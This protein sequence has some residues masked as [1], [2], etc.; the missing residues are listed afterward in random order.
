MNADTPTDALPDS[1]PQPALGLA[2]HH[3]LP[4]LRIRAG[5][6]AQATVLLHGA[7]LVSWI[8][9]G[10]SEQLFVS[11][12][13]RH[14]AGQALRGGVPVIFPQFEQRGPLPRHGLARNRAWQ[15]VQRTQLP[16]HAMAV[17][18]LTDDE[19]TRAIWPQAFVC[20]LTVGIGGPRLDIEL[21]VTHAGPEGAEP[22]RFTAALHTYLRIGELRQVR[23]EGLRGSRYEDSARGG[24]KDV[25]V[26]TELRI[27]EEV[28]RIYLGA[29]RQTLL[30]RE[31]GRRLG[32]SADGFADVVV[33]NPGAEKAA[34][35]P[36]LGPDAWRQMLCVEAAQIGQPVELAAG[37]EWVGRQSLVAG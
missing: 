7:Q 10:G 21:A 22:M 15:A 31:P 3:G 30:L 4:A 33:W 19:A 13:A 34:A 8:P 11:P 2:D 29:G 32:I 37:E 24:R 12:L 26:E 36:D 9:A 6:G 23:L 16:G 5:D 25:E 20:E 27:E 14:A 35:L 1:T 17:L 28:D 18:R